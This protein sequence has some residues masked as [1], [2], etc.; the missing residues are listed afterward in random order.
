MSLTCFSITSTY[1]NP[2]ILNSKTSI[3]EDAED[4][5]SVFLT[6]D[7]VDYIRERL[8]PFKNILKAIFGVKEFE[9]IDSSTSTEGFIN[10]RL[11]IF[12]RFA[13]KVS[14]SFSFVFFKKK[15]YQ[16]HLLI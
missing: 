16:F 15:E 6:G 4:Q 13:E 12:N 1:V 5:I 8:G 2:A 11:D 3:F 7:L 10:T 14:F 9:D